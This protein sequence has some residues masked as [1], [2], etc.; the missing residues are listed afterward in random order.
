M[1]EMPPSLLQTRRQLIEVWLKQSP[2]VLNSYV[3]PN[4]RNILRKDSLGYQCDNC[5]IAYTEEGEER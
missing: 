5:C 2:N 4:C 1:K 3:C